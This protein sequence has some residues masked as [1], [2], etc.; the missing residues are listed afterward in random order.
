MN[1]QEFQARWDKVAPV[2]LALAQ[3]VRG[4]TPLTSDPTTR[5]GMSERSS[6]QTRLL[7]ASAELAALLD[8][9]RLRFYSL[10][11][12]WLRYED[13]DEGLVD[14]WRRAARYKSCVD[15]TLAAQ[16]MD[17]EWKVVRI[18]APAWFK[19]PEFLQWLNHP[20]TATWHHAGS[21]PNDYSDVFFTFCQG[22]GSDY[23]GSLAI[24]G[25]PDEIWKHLEF[26]VAEQHGW[27]AEVL[28]WVSNLH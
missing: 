17:Q 2:V 14:F 16:T 10:I 7:R 1:P 22:E 13:T 4:D 19:N 27:D 8:E 9:H 3:Q 18:D 20:G 15:E 6:R 28:I 5:A 23:P 25:I 26:I 12:S 11:P 24:P 21:D